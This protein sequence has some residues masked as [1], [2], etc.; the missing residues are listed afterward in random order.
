MLVTRKVGPAFGERARFW[1]E[2]KYEDQ[3]VRGDRCA[4]G[5]PNAV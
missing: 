2:N 5:I 3:Y 1:D 4:A